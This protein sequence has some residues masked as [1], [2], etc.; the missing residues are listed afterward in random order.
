MNLWF[1]QKPPSAWEKHPSEK[2]P[3]TLG[4]PSFSLV[5][6]RGVVT[7][8]GMGTRIGRIA[9]L[10]AGEVG[11]DLGAKERQEFFVV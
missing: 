9:Q 7:A 2:F 8:T 6:G 4:D 11:S 5:Q 10:I 3:S 1:F